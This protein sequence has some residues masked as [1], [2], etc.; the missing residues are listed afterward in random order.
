MYVIS[1]GLITQ[2]LKTFDRNKTSDDLINGFAAVLVDDI[3]N[4]YNNQDTNL[5]YDR[6]GYLTTTMGDNLAVESIY[7]E[8]INGLN[9]YT[10]QCGWDPRLKI[11]LT[12]HMIKDHAGNVQQLFVVMDLDAT[13]EALYVAED[14][15][16]GLGELVSDNPSTEELNRVLNA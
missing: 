5:M 4:T 3:I 7:V 1:I 11:K 14:Q 10:K 6:I 15:R 12:H 2:T 9:A 8:Q 13:L 16:Y